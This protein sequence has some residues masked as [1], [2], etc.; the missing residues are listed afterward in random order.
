[1][2]SP[3]SDSSTDLIEVRDLTKT[4][5]L[6]KRGAGIM[7]SLRNLFSA[8]K[9]EITAV[10]AVNFGIKRGELVGYLGPNGA[11]KSTTIKMLTGILQ[12]SSGH[13]RVNGVEP[14]RERRKLT[15]QIGVVFGQKTQL[16]WDL[17]VGESFDLLKT[18]YKIPDADFKRRM[19]LFGDLL[20]IQDFIKQQTRKLSLGQRMRSDLAA[21]LLHNPPVLFLDE[22][23]I[24][25]DILTRE[26]IRKFIKELNAAEKT[27]VILT[28]HD[29]QDIEF[30]ATRLILLD[31]GSIQYDGN[32]E[33]FT[34]QY[35]REKVVSVVL[36]S[37]L[38]VNKLK[39][40]GFDIINEFSPTQ[41]EVRMTANE[42][43]NPLISALNDGGGRIREINVRKQDL[44]DTLKL[45]YQGRKNLE[46]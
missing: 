33:D 37:E 26:A 27:T 22:P 45:I 13:I 44:G 11:G 34:E 9:E 29:M 18:I 17:P 32:I 43:V 16:W 23:T 7:G 24:G 5:T 42:S 3:M 2:L 28:T 31:R 15:K 38:D 1:M 40:A 12:P 35:T 41:F 30:L 20:H 21:S 46:L 19:E 14:G 6:R 8:E 10:D 36:E 39:Q 25:L 4:F